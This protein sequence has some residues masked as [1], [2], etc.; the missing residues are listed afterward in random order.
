MLKYFLTFFI[1]LQTISSYAQFGLRISASQNNYSEWNT[2]VSSATT[3]ANNDLFNTSYELGLD[4][5]FRLKNIR[6]EFYPEIGL[7][8]S[9]SDNSPSS[10]EIFP[11]SYRLKK[12][13]GG[14][15]THLYFLD[16]K[17][18]CKCPTFSKQNDFFKKGLFLILSSKAHFQ[19]KETIYQAQ[20]ISDNDVTLELGGGLGLD[21]G[22]SDLITLSPFGMISY[23]PSSNWDGISANHGI[24]HILPPDETTTNLAFKIGLRIGFR[25]DYLK[26][27]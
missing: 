25:P 9:K 24:I 8:Y 15:N 12:A 13:Y 22:L 17:N 7:G 5:W 10:N 16:L 20:V 4:Y 1:L 3:P 19:N 27:R 18:D 21:I 23:F 6:L 14:I 26:N 11:D 2:I